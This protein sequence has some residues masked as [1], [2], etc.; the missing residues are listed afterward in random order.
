[1]ITWGIDRCEKEKISAYLES[2][3]E[4]V[5]LYK[6]MGFEDLGEMSMNISLISDRTEVITEDY[7]EVAMVYK[8]QA[9]TENRS[10]PGQSS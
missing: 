7:R 5:D 1:M 10:I 6:K 9:T 2:T 4:A 3:V 8:P